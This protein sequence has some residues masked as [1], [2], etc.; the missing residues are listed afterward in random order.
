MGSQNLFCGYI[1]HPVQQTG[2]FLVNA[3]VNGLINILVNI[4]VNVRVNRKC[5]AAVNGKRCG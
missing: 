4:A 1:W 3:E 5:N 2:W